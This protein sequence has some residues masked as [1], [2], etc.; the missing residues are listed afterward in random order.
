MGGHWTRW[1]AGPGS[2]ISHRFLN[3]LTVCLPIDGKP[4][5]RRGWSEWLDELVRW[6]ERERERERGVRDWSDE[7]SVTEDDKTRRQDTD[8]QYLTASDT[9]TH[10]HTHT[11]TERQT[12]RQTDNDQVSS[13]SGNLADYG[14]CVVNASLSTIRPPSL[15]LLLSPLVVGWNV[16]KPITSIIN[17]TNRR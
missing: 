5:A 9:H 14:H 8:K 2:S 3:G 1:P 13:V 16:S 12:D 15:V 4:R 11:Y 10:T 17:S 6:R 7:W